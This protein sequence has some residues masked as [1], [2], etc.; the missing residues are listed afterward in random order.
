MENHPILL[1]VNSVSGQ[2]EALRGPHRGGTALREPIEWPFREPSEKIWQSSAV[3]LHAVGLSHH[4]DMAERIFPV[5]G[6]EIEV[7]QSK[8]LLK[9]GRIWSARNGHDNG[10]VVS[11]VIA[12]DK[13]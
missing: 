11:H 1:I 3:N 2:R 7:V 13:A 5:I 8:R 9:L 12:P 6:T 4:L 10:V